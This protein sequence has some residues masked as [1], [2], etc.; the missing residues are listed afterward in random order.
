MQT[1]VQ[2]HHMTGAGMGVKAHDRETMPLCW[3]CHA[4]LHGRDLHG[5]AGRFGFMTKHDLRDWQVTMVL[6]YQKLYDGGHG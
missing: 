6:L 4:D 3:R 2:V 5:R 1:P